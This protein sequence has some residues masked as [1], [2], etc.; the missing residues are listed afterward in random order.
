MLRIHDILA[1]IRIR[2]SMPLTKD[3]DPDPD[4]FAIDLQDVNKKLILKKSFSSYY[5]LKVVFHRFS[6]VKS[7]NEV[8]K[9]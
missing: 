8:T 6:K 1:R 5:F 3:P 2:G 4:V 7:Q 9:Q